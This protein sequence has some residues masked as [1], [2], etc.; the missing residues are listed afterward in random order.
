MIS[1][2]RNFAK[3]RTAKV[4]MVIIIIPFVF[5]GMGDFTS[6][7]KNVVVVIDKEKYSSQNFVDF[8][9]RPHLI[10]WKSNYSGLFSECLK[11]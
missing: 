11:N 8:I 9:Q 4:L 5:W 3:T 10:Q 2:L 1:T 7:G 6:G